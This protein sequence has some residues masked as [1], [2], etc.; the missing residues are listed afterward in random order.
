[1]DLA[2]GEV[3]VPNVNDQRDPRLLHPAPAPPRPRLLARPLRAGIRV[4]LEVI[5]SI[6][7]SKLDWEKPSGKAL[8]KTANTSW[9]A[10][11]RG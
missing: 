11:R 3:G 8:T 7:F 9:R 10:G 6:I 2:V 1:V 5:I 4:R